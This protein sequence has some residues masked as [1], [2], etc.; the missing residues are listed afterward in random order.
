MSSSLPSHHQQRAA[1]L[2]SPKSCWHHPCVCSYSGKGHNSEMEHLVFSPWSC[3]SGP[4]AVCGQVRGRRVACY[5]AKD[6][7]HPQQR[8]TL[9]CTSKSHSG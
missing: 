7:H 8:A 3:L 6:Q 2:C 4:Q 1:L 5:P 9:I